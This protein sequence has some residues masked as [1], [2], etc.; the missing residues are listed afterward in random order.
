MQTPIRILLV[1]DHPVVR[2]GLAAMLA[3]EPEFAV[4]GMA[5]TI[6]DAMLRVGE[7]APDLLLLD[8]GLPD[9]NGVAV[10]EALRAQGHAARVIVFTAFDQDAQIM[11]A[12]RAGA[13]GYLLKGAP[14][15]EL[16]R[17]IRSVH[18]GGS[19]IEPAVASK[20]LRQ[21]RGNEDALTPREREV[22]ALLMHGH[23]NKVIARQLSVSERTVKFHVGAILAK[24]GARN[25]TQAVAAARE[26]GLA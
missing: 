21:M 19:L 2:D 5:G 1:D 16:F 26:R 11:A 6:A 8:L 4:I 24:L 3:T 9:G 14:R 18:A 12:I 20:L 7:L 17:A 15:E 10:I 13:Q 25:R 22:L 23:P